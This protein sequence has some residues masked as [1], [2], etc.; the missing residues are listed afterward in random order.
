MGR[1]W[2]CAHLFVGPMWVRL[3]SSGLLNVTLAET[4]LAQSLVLKYLIEEDTGEV[5]I[6]R[7]FQIMSVCP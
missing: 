3:A 7:T 5:S 4:N 2:V 6:S 1:L